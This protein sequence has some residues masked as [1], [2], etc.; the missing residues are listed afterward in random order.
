MHSQRVTK[1]M[2]PIPVPTLYGG[3][4]EVYAAMVQQGRFTFADDVPFANMWAI[5]RCNIIAPEGGVR[6]LSIPVEKPTNGS[7]TLV[8]DLRIANQ[9]DWER[10][11]LGAITS[12][13]GRT[14]FFEYIAAD[15]NHL[16][17]NHSKWLAEFN[18]AL[19]NLI[20]DYLDIRA[21]LLLTNK[22]EIAEPI[23]LHPFYTAT[24]RKSPI[25]HTVVPYYQHHRQQ[26]NTFEPRLSIMDL[27]FNVGREGIFTLLKMNKID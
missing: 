2:L 20:C 11:H 12:T 8:R 5:S 10:V 1:D 24:L 26:A 7:R 25:L 19:H 15:L 17:E 18:N 14:P 23:V 6:T 16:Y 27:L 3:G 4:I 22:E 13:Y 9:G 21:T